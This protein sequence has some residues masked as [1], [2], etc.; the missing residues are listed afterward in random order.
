MNRPYLR[1]TVT[2][3]PD[4]ADDPLPWKVSQPHPDQDGV[5]V[6]QYPTQS[7]AVTFADR[8]STMY[9]ELLMEQR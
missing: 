2:R 5:R 9:V 3:R 1:I 7:Q 8:L 4:D 6:G